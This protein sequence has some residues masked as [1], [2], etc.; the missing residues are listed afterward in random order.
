MHIYYFII[1]QNFV[2][3]YFA[4]TRWFSLGSIE[5]ILYFW[6]CLSSL[7]IFDFCK[8]S[9]IS[10][11][12]VILSLFIPFPFSNSQFRSFHHFSISVCVVY[13]RQELWALKNNSTFSTSIIF[14]VLFLTEYLHLWIYLEIRYFCALSISYL[15]FETIICAIFDKFRVFLRIFML[16]YSKHSLHRITFR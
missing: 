9:M 6:T 2:I 11:L 7:N 4:F 8:L 3:H 10:V 12:H 16:R 1:Y 14:F 13:W 5:D 15:F